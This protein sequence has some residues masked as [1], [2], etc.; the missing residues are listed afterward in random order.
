MP[1]EQKQ[2]ILYT[3]FDDFLIIYWCLKQAKL[4]SDKI[5]CGNILDNDLK[6]IKLCLDS[7]IVINM[8]NNCFEIN[9]SSLLDQLLS[10]TDEYNVTSIMPTGF[11]SL[12]FMSFY[13]NDF[14]KIFIPLCDYDKIQKLDNKVSFFHFCK[15]NSLSHPYS[16]DMSQCNF[17]DDIKI[18]F[19]VL[20]KIPF[21]SASK[22]NI[23]CNNYTELK[24]I[25]VK[26]DNNILVQEI[27]NGFDVA[28]NAY[29]L[30]GEIM[31]W[32]I[33]KFIEPS[34]SLRWSQFIIDN[35]IYNIAQKLIN[36][37]SYTGPINIDMRIDTVSDKIYLIEVNPR[38][39]ANTHYSIIDG[40]NFIDVALKLISSSEYFVKPR[41]SNKIWGTPHK[42]LSLL[43]TGV[44]PLNM[45]IYYVKNQSP[46]QIKNWIY[47]KFLKYRAKLNL[48][49]Y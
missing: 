28:F 10:L 36:I 46:Y 34:S 41:G 2:I 47:G 19:P 5:L 24:K 42:L 40:I 15:D 6:K 17:I 1:K 37:V 48:K 20:I 3:S 29:A 23:L 22:G 31:A 49:V 21:A 11:S 9:N 26:Y 30:N 45:V 14:K 18:E 13:K 27:I 35:N 43:T 39:W 7:P 44:I 25:A 8:P 38:F 32:S 16:I 4:C 33:Q 12:K